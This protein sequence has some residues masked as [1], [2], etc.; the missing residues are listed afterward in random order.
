MEV[1]VGQDNSELSCSPFFIKISCAGLGVGM[2]LMWV[3]A[4]TQF[5]AEVTVGHA[6]QLDL[7]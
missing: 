7:S 3:K 1:T 4:R 2:V 6:G 5:E